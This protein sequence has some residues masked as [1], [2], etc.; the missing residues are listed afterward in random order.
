MQRLSSL[1]NPPKSTDFLSTLH[2]VT[3]TLFTPRYIGFVGGGIL[4]FLFIAAAV[5]EN[6]TKPTPVLQHSDTNS[7]S[8]MQNN[9]SSDSPPS[10][11]SS[12]TKAHLRV[13]GQDIPIPSNSDTTQTLTKGDTQ[14][15]VHTSEN[16]T[17]SSNNNSSNLTINVDSVTSGGT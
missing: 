15:V 9:V 10:A 4:L 12:Q 3:H 7:D 14:T 13:N 2:H 11:G 16:S 6:S 8:H 1:T 5:I 17:Q